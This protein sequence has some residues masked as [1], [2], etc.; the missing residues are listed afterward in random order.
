MYQPIFAYFDR[1]I[2]AKNT[3]RIARTKFYYLAAAVAASV[4]L[5]LGMWHTFRPADTQELCLCSANYVVINGHCYTDT[6]KARSLAL[7]AL[8]EVAAPDEVSFPGIGSFYNE[9]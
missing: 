2:Q 6:Q 5:L 7:E 4:A 8:K 1:E 9:E 3:P